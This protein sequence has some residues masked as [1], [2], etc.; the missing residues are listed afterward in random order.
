[1]ETDMG[2]VLRDKAF[3]FSNETAHEVDEVLLRFAS[4][5]V[6]SCLQESQST[7]MGGCLNWVDKP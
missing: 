7:H 6:R 5:W 2:G 1:M 4:K 3:G